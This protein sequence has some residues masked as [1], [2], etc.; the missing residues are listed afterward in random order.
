METPNKENLRDLWN[1]EVVR[2]QDIG[3]A[4]FADS[5]CDYWL[6]VLSER[7]EAVV[8]KLKEE[9]KFGKIPYQALQFSDCPECGTETNQ[10]WVD[11]K[12]KEIKDQAL[13]TCIAIIR[14]ENK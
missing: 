3:L 12:C 13:S 1:K 8:K 9:K 4:L 14:G 6:K 5:I 10:V 2:V 11:A 7:E